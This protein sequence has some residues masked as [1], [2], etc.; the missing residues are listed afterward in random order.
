[1]VSP[2]ECEEY[3]GTEDVEEPSLIFIPPGSLPGK[4][5][6]PKVY[7]PVLFP[8]LYGDLISDERVKELFEYWRSEGNSYQCLGKTLSPRG[9]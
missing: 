8:I 6:A 1:M 3:T 5:E 9:N 2:G 4:T 7:I